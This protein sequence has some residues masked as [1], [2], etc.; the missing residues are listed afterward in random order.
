MSNTCA[1]TTPLGTCVGPLVLPRDDLG[2]Q[3]V[4]FWV[5]WAKTFYYY[6]GSLFLW[7]LL[8][9]QPAV[10]WGKTGASCSQL[11]GVP[12]MF[13]FLFSRRLRL[14]LSH[15]GISG[16]VEQVFVCV[17]VTLLSSQD[18]FKYHFRLQTLHSA[19]PYS[20]ARFDLVYFINKQI[21]CVWW[22]P[23]RQGLSPQVEDN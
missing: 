16:H 10:S 7:T 9:S 15:V 21:I 5:V 23:S 18:D 12:A 13:Q 6:F 1:I 20:F 8:Q 19:L 4:F 3:S 22:W 17:C 14:G 11:G 2:L